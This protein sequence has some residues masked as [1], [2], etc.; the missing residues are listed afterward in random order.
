[1]THGTFKPPLPVNEPVRDYA[2]GSPERQ[3]LEKRLKE[4]AAET[5]DVPLIIGGPTVR[6]N[7]PSV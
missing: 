4:M 1:M 7:A 2:P 6:S 5:V 3:S